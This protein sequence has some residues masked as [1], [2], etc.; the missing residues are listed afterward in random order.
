M[1][2]SGMLCLSYGGLQVH[3]LNAAGRKQKV[4]GGAAGRLYMNKYLN[5]GILHVC[6]CAC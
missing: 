5:L 6:I 3:L 1:L 2:G 4:R